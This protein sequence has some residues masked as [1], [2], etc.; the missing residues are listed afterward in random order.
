MASKDLLKTL[1]G[2][3]KRAVF[4]VLTA[5]LDNLCFSYAPSVYQ[6]E[7][8]EYESACE[9][10]WTL[11]QEFKDKSKAVFNIETRRYEFK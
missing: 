10:L 4:D 3:E 9:Y 11:R 6:C 8:C 2:K 5:A 1:T 7:N